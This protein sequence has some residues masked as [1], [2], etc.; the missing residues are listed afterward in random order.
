MSR[1]R[2][3]SRRGFL[4]ASAGA[5]VG[6]A[7]LPQVVPAAVLG[8]DGVVAPGGRVTVGCIGV[9]IQG[10]ALLRNFLGQGAARVVAVCDVNAHRSAAAKRLVDGRYG[11]TDC[12]V[13]GDFRT[14]LA[15]GDIDAVVIAP[16]DHWHV[17]VATAAARAGKDMYLEKPIGV[18]VAEARSLGKAVRRYG[19]VFQ[20]GTQQRSGERFRLACEIVR[21]GLIGELKHVNV[22]S[23]GSRSGGSLE[24]TPP[25]GWLDYDMWLGPAPFAPHTR[26]RCTNRFEPGDPEK[27]WPF[28]S[29][30]CVGW[31]SG[32]GVHPLDIALWGAPRA[33]AGPFEIEGKGVFP[34]EGPCDTAT[35]W[36]LA[37]RYDTGVTLN[38]TGVPASPAWQRRYGK[39]A[40]HGTVFEGAAGWVHVDRERLNTYPRSLATATIGADRTRLY[41]SASHV[42]NFIDCVKSRRET[43]SSIDSALAVEALC[44]ASAIAVRLNRPLKWDPAGERFAG[45]AEADRML[46]R[47]MRAPWHL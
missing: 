31:I 39:C 30:Y 10:T 4:R 18:S 36:R 27:I 42:G 38:F 45:D 43:I 44:Q 12:A 37:L 35:N 25:P 24:V 19:R 22:W 7:V 8:R 21:N 14:L 9:G 32:W 47:A 33:L 2:E 11:D 34:S 5:A 15:R 23:P 17:V 29:D 41:R 3:M 20:F 13:Y 46:S 6:T 40:S 26:H 1:S 28:I 16:P